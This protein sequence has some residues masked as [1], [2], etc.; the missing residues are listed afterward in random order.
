MKRTKH[1]NGIWKCNRCECMLNVVI[2]YAASGGDYLTAPKSL[3]I[4]VK[5]DSI[6]RWMPISGGYLHFC[7]HHHNP[8]E[9]RRQHEQKAD[10]QGPES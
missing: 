8:S 6:K 5:P 2:K 7:R 9:T 1:N 3:G 4:L 10:Q